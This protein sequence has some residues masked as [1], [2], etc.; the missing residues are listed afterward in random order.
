MNPLR[1][2]SNIAST[3]QADYVQFTPMPYRSNARGG[4]TRGGAG[5]PAG[6]GATPVI[7][8]MPNSTPSVGSQQ[9]WG[10]KDFPGPLGSAQRDLGTAIAGGVMDIGSTP[11]SSLVEGVKNNLNMEN[12]LKAAGSIA[13]QA[14]L[15][16]IPQQLMGGTPNQMIA[17][18]KGE[19]YNPNVELLYTSPQMRGFSFNFEFV[20]KNEQE[21]MVMNQIIKNF[22]KWSAPAV[23]EAGMFEIPHVWKVEYMTAGSPNENMNQFKKAACTSITI[24]ANP[25]T[26]MH[27]AHR[28]GSPISTVMQLTFREVDII[29]RQD[30]DESRGQGF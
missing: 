5:A 13:R 26:N 2:P 3:D 14:A 19:V 17:L 1:Y 28:D 10:R 16:L 29:T 30:Q 22:K 7:L 8:Y 15:K 4:P 11:I 24:Q 21:T 20:P 6:A 25:S 9:D 18:S 23:L 12:N 27:V